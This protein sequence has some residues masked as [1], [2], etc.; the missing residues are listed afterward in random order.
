M[1]DYGAFLT[2]ALTSII[3]LLFWAGSTFV[4]KKFREYPKV[5]LV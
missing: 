5:P 2:A 4:L 3:A 1:Y